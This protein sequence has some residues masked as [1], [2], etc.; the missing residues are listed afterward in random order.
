M[1]NSY[2]VYWWLTKMLK[3]CLESVWRVITTCC[4]LA[5]CIMF[6]LPWIHDIGALNDNFPHVLLAGHTS[7]LQLKISF[8]SLDKSLSHCVESRNSLK[9]VAR[10]KSPPFTVTLTAWQI[11]GV[12]VCLE[13][14]GRETLHSPDTTVFLCLWLVWYTAGFNGVSSGFVVAQVP[15]PSLTFSNRGGW[16]KQ[17]TSTCFSVRRCHK[18]VHSSRVLDPQH[19]LLKGTLL[20]WPYQIQTHRDITELVSNNICAFC[21]ILQT[22]IVNW[23][24]PLW[25]YCY[26]LL[27]FFLRFMIACGTASTKSQVTS[28][29]IL[30]E[31]LT[32]V[33]VG[34]ILS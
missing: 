31:T 4:S 9:S 34:P 16:R 22:W 28:I 3:H 7:V 29:H 25:D 13:T 26:I 21:G 15:L 8:N 30:H 12:F 20:T 18:D 11:W 27:Y 2:T 5:K 33:W 6:L 32:Y 23:S 17:M 14:I 19:I 24:R 1:I 10:I